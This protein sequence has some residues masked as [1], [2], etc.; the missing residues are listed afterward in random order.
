MLPLDFSLFSMRPVRGN[1]ES[2]FYSTA[3]EPGGILRQLPQDG[4]ETFNPKFCYVV[5]DQAAETHSG[6]FEKLLEKLVV[7]D[8][9]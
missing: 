1:T 5:S 6:S 9:S 3:H 8:S 4:V 7:L 2:T